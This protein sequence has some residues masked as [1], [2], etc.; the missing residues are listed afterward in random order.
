MNYRCI[1]TLK[2]L[3]TTHLSVTGFSSGLL[4]E[5]ERN[6]ASSGNRD[7]LTRYID[8]AI[9]NYSIAN[10]RL[11]SCSGCFSLLTMGLRQTVGS[12]FEKVYK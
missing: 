8:S 11:F 9:K 12:R 10:R 7:A 3:N 6:S 1:G 5:F 2:C 4:F